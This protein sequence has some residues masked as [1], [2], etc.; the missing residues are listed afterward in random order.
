[1]RLPASLGQC[2]KCGRIMLIRHL[3][4]GA[5]RDKWDCCGARMH[6][7]RREKELAEERRDAARREADLLS[8]E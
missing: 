7:W 4:G 8:G 3:K 2:Q 6:R 5:C 1:M